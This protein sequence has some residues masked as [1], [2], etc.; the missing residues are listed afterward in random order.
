MIGTLRHRLILQ[1]PTVT[2]DGGGG[3]VRGWTMVT[4]LWGALSQKSGQEKTADG[5][6]RDVGHTEVVIRYR[7][8]VTAQMRFVAT[9]RVLN[10]VSVLDKE[11]G[12]RWLTCVC[13][14]ESA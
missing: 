2:S 11:G 6:Y 7:S 14:E 1:K 4:K 13:R 10:I 3:Q 12:R 9:G 5:D 8:D